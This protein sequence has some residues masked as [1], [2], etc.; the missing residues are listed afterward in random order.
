MAGL[1]E[2]ADAIKSSEGK[3]RKIA[4]E[5]RKDN[6][7]FFPVKTEK[8]DYSVCAVDGGLLSERFHGT[9][10]IMG[11]AVAVLFEYSDSKLSSCRYL[12]DKF[13]VSVM[14]A[15]LGLDEH[16]S[17]ICSSL[18]RLNM[19]I[20]TAIEAVKNLSPQVLLFDGSLLPVPSDMPGKDSI[21][22]PR[23]REVLDSYAEL[24]KTCKGKCSLIGV[25]KDS[26]SRRFV[27]EL[28]INEDGISDSY[29]T[30]FLLRKGESTRIF[31]YAKEET[32]VTKELKNVFSFYLKP[33]DF[34]LP[35]RIEFVDDNNS[36]KIPVIVNSLSAISENYAYPAS[37]IEADLC[38]VMNPVEMEKV[39]S[40]LSSLLGSSLKPLRRS[41]RPFR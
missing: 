27:K 14:D 3:I 39:K 41:S 20:K 21:L 36:E 12:P 24:Y 40:E 22:F 32:P 25:I 7:L 15:K 34:D 26:R 5:F 38:A 31:P 16:E 18:F 28:G 13:P 1:S 11:K 23:Y 29:F 4:E 9:D 30:N 17:Q 2:V 10:I 33:S 35:L 6:S 37:L 8:I 19:E